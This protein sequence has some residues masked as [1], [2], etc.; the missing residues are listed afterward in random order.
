MI[1]TIS[2][3]DKPISH[4]AS[5]SGSTFNLDS[6]SDNND[7]KNNGSSSTQYG[8]KNNND[9]DSNSNSETYIALID[10]TK[11]QELKWFN[12]N[13]KGIKPK[14]VHN[15]NA[16][17]DLRYPEKDLIKLEPYS[18]TCIDLKI[19][20]EIPA[21]TM[22]QLTFRSSLVKKVI[23]I[24]G[25]I[26]DARYVENI[27]T[28]LQNNSEKAYIIDP[29]EK[30]AQA[31]F[32]PLVKVAQLVLVKN[33]EKLRITTREIQRFGS[34][35][36]IDVPVNMAKEEVIDKGKIIS[37]H[38]SISISPYD[39]YMLAIKKK[40]KNQAQLFEAEAT[41]CKLGEIGLTNLY[42]LAKSPK[43]I[44][45]S[46]HNTIGSVIEIPKETIIR[47]LTIEV[48]DQ[49]PNHIPDFSQLC[50]YVDITSQTIYRQN[51]CYLLQPE[52][53]E[54]INIG[55]LDPLQQM[56]LKILLSNFNDIFTSKNEFGHTNII[57]HQIK[58]KDA[59]LIK[60]KT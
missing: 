54:Q 7:N 24:R 17:F 19:A 18:C 49:P 32:L 55:N 27:I 48:E 35:G 22:V 28:I 14:R 33:R 13:N 11:K 16:G 9:S 20:L 8:N 15:T 52:Q 36:R 43:N 39:Q 44:K 45:I 4:C 38:Q 21:T 25:K 3:E 46:I 40:V 58:T 5:E 30:I 34:T 1:Y 12:N 26:I 57:Q 53:L 50:E 23:T 41:I 59:M 2:K 51:K 29:K 37:T 31:I 47:Y 6:N 56:Q 42:I 60:Q 10:L